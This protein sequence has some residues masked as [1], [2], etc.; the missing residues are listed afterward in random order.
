VADEVIKE[1]LVKLGVDDQ[2]TRRMEESLRDIA[3]SLQVLLKV[4]GAF[5]MKTV[6]GLD[7]VNDAMKELSDSTDS[8]AKPLEGI[9]DDLEELG[10]TAKKPKDSMKAF[11]AELVAINAALKDNQ[12][13]IALWKQKSDVLNGELVLSANKF[14][15]LNKIA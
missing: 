3:A 7:G 4:F 11:E 14:N 10:E 2:A 1:Y 12:D 5:V 9:A 6:G 13:S 15:E 8:A